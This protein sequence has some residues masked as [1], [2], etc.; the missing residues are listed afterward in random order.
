MGLRN[1]L[2]IMIGRNFSDRPEVPVKNIR[3]VMLAALDHKCCGDHAQLAQKIVLRQDIGNLWYLRYELMRAIS[4]CGH[5][6]V[7]PEIL[8]KIT[9]VFQGHHPSA[10]PMFVVPGS[11]IKKLG[12]FS[13]V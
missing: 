8:T 12:R 6:S 3:A 10:T 7:D 4:E 1:S 13:S 5:T 2:W 11:P 9:T